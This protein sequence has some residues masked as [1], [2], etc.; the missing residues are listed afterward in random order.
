MRPPP[1]PANCLIAGKGD[2]ESA[3][4]DLR[5]PRRVLQ[6]MARKQQRKKRKKQGTTTDDIVPLEPTEVQRHAWPILL[7]D[8]DSHPFRLQNQGTE[9]SFA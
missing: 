1:L 7:L 8:R 9:I 6:K 4:C 2:D 3:Q 5:L